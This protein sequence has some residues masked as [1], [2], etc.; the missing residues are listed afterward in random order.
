MSVQPAGTFRD[1]AQTTDGSTLQIN[2]GHFSLDTDERTKAF[3]AK[4]AVGWEEDYAEYRR[5]WVELPKTR[6]VREYPLLLDLELASLCNLKC[7]M[8]YTITPEFKSKV[9]KGF[10]DFALFRRII[11]EVKNE[12]YSVR[13]SFRGEATLHPNFL[14]CVAYAKQAGV[15]EVSTLTNGSKL[16]GDYFAALVQA[17]IDWVTFSI[18]GTGET[19]EK[20]R[21]PIKFQQIVD[22][23]TEIREYKE[24]RGLAKPV[25]KVQGVWP[26]VRENPEEYYQTFAPI[27]DLVAFNP[28]I[29]YL[30]NDDEILYEDNFTCPQPYQRLVIGSDGRA[31]MCT[32]DE[33]GEIII[34][35]ANEQTIGEIWRGKPLQEMRERHHE[36][37]GFKS[38]SPCRKCYYPRKAEVNESAVVD[39]R[40]ILVENYV[41]RPQAVG[42]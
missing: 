31:M 34:G 14:D 29:D 24:N 11:D 25:I 13:V 26:A 30:R 41:N 23:L 35:D 1:S 16:R 20:I 19:Y 33:D 9:T 22:T 2:K 10:I 32:N 7:P 42:E 36:D 27:S 18:D 3:G 17:G 12:V 38:L 15:R 5:L 40:T 6:T 21:R 39:G 8:C 4:L 28:L 37:N